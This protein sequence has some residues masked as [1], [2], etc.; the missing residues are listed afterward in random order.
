MIL[1]ITNSNDVTTSEI[2]EWLLAEGHHILRLNECD[3]ITSFT[4]HNDEISLNIYQL[5]TQKNI[6]LNLND[7]H[8][9]WYRKGDIRF[10]DFFKQLFDHK[11]IDRYVMEELEIVQYYLYYILSTKFNL[12][13]V[14]NRSM[15]KLQVNHLAKSVGLQVPENIISTQKND[16]LTFLKNHNN[17]CITKAI[18]EGITVETTD[19]FVMG[20]TEA[21]NSSDLEDYAEVIQPNLIQEKIDKRYELRIFYLNG[22]CYTSAIFSQND[23]Q[24]AVDFRKYNYVK[25]NRTVPFQL[26]A[27][28]ADKIDRLM[29]IV[30]LKSG[31][32]DI[33]VNK[34]GE[35]IFLEINPVGQFGMVSVPCNYFLE[36]KVAH[37]LTTATA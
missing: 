11:T 31:S 8:T 1:I 2:M 16:L 21:I 5:S 9:V 30:K 35:Y 3:K 17:S 4:I 10:D 15:N 29:K 22:I 28:I 33:L 13:T 7:V 37:Y 12:A 36:Q 20:Y 27:A 25:P 32:I 14:F 34:K 18:S 6:Q 26:P 23:K 19:G 24:T